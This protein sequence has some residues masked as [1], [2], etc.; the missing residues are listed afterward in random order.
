MKN[1][2]IIFGNGEQLEFKILNL[3][4]VMNDI[5]LN[6]I[7]FNEKYKSFTFLTDFKDTKN[8]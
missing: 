6:N 1:Q 3:E 2:K 4:K 7:E 5:A 8:K